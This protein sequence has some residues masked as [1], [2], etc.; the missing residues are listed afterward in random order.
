MDYAYDSEHIHR[1]IHE[2]LQ[3]QS[4]IPIPTGMLRMF[5]ANTGK[6]LRVRS[7]SKSIAVEIWPSQFSRY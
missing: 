4:M 7:T 1:L 3:S 6:S 2:D 5:L